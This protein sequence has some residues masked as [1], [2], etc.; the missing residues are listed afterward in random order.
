M[1]F[2]RSRLEEAQMILKIDHKS[3]DPDIDVFAMAGRLTMGSDS[4]HVEWN[5]AKILKENHK[6]VIFDLAN[7][8]FLDS[9]GI[10]ILVMCHA[11]LKKAGGALRIAG[12]Q[13]MVQQVLEMTNV[14]K[15]VEFYPSASEAAKNFTIA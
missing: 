3:M 1:F 14:N 5:L 9:S 8:N 6:K 4:Q 13:G 7:V 11:K 12:A 10:G 2:A 15:I